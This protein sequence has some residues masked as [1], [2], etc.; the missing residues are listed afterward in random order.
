MLF[1]SGS[2]VRRA[3]FDAFH[4]THPGVRVVNTGGLTLVGDLADNMFL[5]AMAGGTAPDVFYVN[6]ADQRLYRTRAG[7]VTPVTPAEPLRL[8]DFIIDR[9]RARVISVCE[10]HRTPGEPTNSLVAIGIG[11]DAVQTPRT[12]ASAS[13]RRPLPC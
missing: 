3:V 12:M 4:K 2:V 6:F 5:M 8:A 7:R 1:R 11:A 10:D 13:S 9:T